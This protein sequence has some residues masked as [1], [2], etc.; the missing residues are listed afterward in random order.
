MRK[1]LIRI[2][3]FFLP[4]LIYCIL[5]IF[6]VP[7]LLTIQNGPSTKQQIEFSF[8]NAV[9][10]DYNLLILGNSR[11]YRGLNPNVFTLKTFN[12]SHDNDSYNQIY[13]KLKYLIDR[14]KE[15]DYL[16]LGIDYFQFSILSDTRNYI[17]ADFFD[18]DYLK[19]YKT[20]I[21]R[22][23][24]NYHIGNLNPKKLLSLIPKGGKATL[25]ENG[26]YLKP[27]FA[28]ENDTIHRDISRLKVQ[29]DYF[30]KIINLCKKED[31]TV[32]MVML[33]IRQ[34]ELNSYRIEDIEKFEAYINTLV[35][36]T[37]VYYLNFSTNPDYKTEDYT[38][39]THLNEK[40]ADRFSKVLNDS[41]LNIIKA[42]KVK[43]RI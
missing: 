20:N 32:F 28:K 40:A 10:R 24:F 29:E 1:F 35:D 31:I 43:G 41:L 37:N 3:I 21:L 15:I 23:K 25:R 38:D 30:S 18:A 42:D 17:Y 9:K 27:G 39:I 33:P 6:T 7:S 11:T 36:N 19:D 12:F 4:A 13:F 34:N 2:T 14:K 8:E 5:A 22:L 16:V 26:Q